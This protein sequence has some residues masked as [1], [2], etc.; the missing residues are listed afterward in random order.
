MSLVRQ[1]SD[2]RVTLYIATAV[3]TIA[4][5]IVP[6]NHE[7]LPQAA[8]YIANMCTSNIHYDIKG[9]YSVGVSST[10]YWY[11]IA[12]GIATASTVNFIGAHNI[13]GLSD[14]HEAL[15]VEYFAS[16]ATTGTFIL[17]LQIW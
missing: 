8:V 16:A 13:S 17:Q 3:T 2:A 5:Q 9:C 6:I 10:A 4:T 1:E 15:T 12:S 14:A 11:S 7:G